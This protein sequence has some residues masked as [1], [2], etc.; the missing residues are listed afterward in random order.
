MKNH[1]A[2]WLVAFGCLAPCFAAHAQAEVYT[3]WVIR[4]GDGPQPFF[5][6]YGRTLEIAE[7]IA[8]GACG[9]DC[10]ILKSGRG[11]IS[12]VLQN[13]EFLP[14]GCVSNAPPETRSEG[15]T[16]RGGVA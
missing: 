2:A 5:F 14:R 8:L 3:V 7:R 6:G 11:C 15:A 10:R 16:P 12:I 1:I 13:E 4:N 9:E